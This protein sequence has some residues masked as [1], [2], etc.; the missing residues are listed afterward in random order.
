MAQ[1]TICWMR[2]SGF[3]IGWLVLCACGEAE[4]RKKGRGESKKTQQWC[5]VLASVDESCVVSVIEG[6][7]GNLLGNRPGLRVELEAA[8]QTGG[9]GLSDSAVM[10]VT[11]ASM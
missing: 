7:S 2:R 5:G 10:R 1:S 3:V 6:M 9:V 8:D 4:R 11:G